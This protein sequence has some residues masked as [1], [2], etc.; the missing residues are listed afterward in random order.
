M[1]INIKD[2]PWLTEAN[3]SDEQA[4]YMLIALLHEGVLSAR[5][6]EDGALFFSYAW[7]YYPDGVSQSEAI[8]ELG[9]MEFDEAGQRI[10]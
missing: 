9:A 8:A 4:R 3:W 1:N 5:R 10:E 2:S 7:A 6:G